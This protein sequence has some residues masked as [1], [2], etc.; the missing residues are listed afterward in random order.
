MLDERCLTLGLDALSRAHTL[1][2]F[3]DGHR[4][5]AIISAYYLCRENA[6]ED[7]VAEI[8]AELIDENWAGTELCDPFPDEPSDPA[9]LGRIVE[10]M[11]PNVGDYRMVGHN[12]IFPACAL[13]AF[14]QVP[15]A[16]TPSRVEGICKL[17]EAF[18][19]VE[20]ITLDDSDQFPDVDTP[21]LMADFI[22]AEALRTMEAFL[23]RGQGWTG[24][25]LTFG[26]ALIDLWQLGHTDLVT[27]G[28]HAFKQYVK[29]A[30]MGPLER[31]IPRAEHP[32]GEL[33]PLERAYWEAR[34]TQGVNIGHC[35]KYPYGFYGLMALARSDDTKQRCLA[36]GYRIF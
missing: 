8:L 25:M 17:I 31:D 18:D 22:L 1:N 20:D 34:K 11:H 2:Y 5:A 4:G 30:R 28:Q 27:K 12:V 16:V 24:H 35:F 36:E 14:V 33:R 32:P 6:V 23:D 29:R 19:T 26:R 3:A 10:T 15:D 21:E 13:K 9:L 7:G